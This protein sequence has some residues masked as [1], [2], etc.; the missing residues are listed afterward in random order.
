MNE[1]IYH[2]QLDILPPDRTN[3]AVTIIGAGGIGSTTALVLS[4]IGFANL[5]VFDDDTIENENVPSQVFRVSDVGRPKVDALADI[6]K[7]FSD[8]D[9]KPHQTR[10]DGHTATKI[11]IGAVDSMESRKTIYEAIKSLYHIELYVDGRMSGEMMRLTAIKPSDPGHQA[12]Y[13]KTLYTD[14]EAQPEAC[15]ARA[16]A[17]NTFLIG[18]FIGNIVKRHVTGQHVPREVIFS[19]ANYGMYAQ[20]LAE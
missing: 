12:M 4:K 2:R 20:G 5:T 11:V 7:D 13:E 1:T 14:E 6:V 3:A 8:A 17:Y 9:I 18:G 15:T 16:V 19:L 10:Y